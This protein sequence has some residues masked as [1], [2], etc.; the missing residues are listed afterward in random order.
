MSV[1]A[2]TRTALQRTSDPFGLVELLTIEDGGLPAPVRLVNDTREFVSAGQTYLPLPFAL[3]FPEAAAGEVPRALLRVDNVGLE[4]TADLEALPPGAELMATVAAAYRKTPD[5]IEYSFKAPLFGVR[6]D[7][8]SINASAGPGDLMRR[9][10]VAIRY[11]PT[12]APGLF[13]D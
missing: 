12:T 9:P 13:P 5:T 8:M 7:L 3:T 11:D 2:T 10:A 1:S 6:A 4:I